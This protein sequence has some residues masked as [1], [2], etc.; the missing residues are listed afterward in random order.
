MNR[1]VRHLIA[2]AAAMLGLMIWQILFASV[3]ALKRLS[4]FDADVVYS[5]VSQIV[6][7]GALPL[8]VLLALGGSEPKNTFR[9]MRYKPP[10]DARSCLLICLGLILLI[11]PFTMA[12]NALTNLLFAVFGYKRSHPVGTI[13]LGVGDFFAMLAVTAL[14][15]A[16]FEEF[17]HRGVLLSGLEYRGSERT[18]IL[19]SAVLFGLMHTSPSQMIFATFG[20]IVFAYVAIKCDSILPAMCAHFANNAI[21]VLLDYSSQTQNALGVW[22]DKVSGTALWQVALTFAVLALS[23]FGMVRLMQ[24]AARKAPKPVSEGRL[25]G[26]TTVDVYNPEGK[27]TLSD[28][29]LLWGVTIS[30]S[31]LLVGLFLW[32]ILK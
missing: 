15:P 29:A 31:V 20:G 26:V 4:D 1:R 25:L 28:N 17:S 2:Y 30:E 23:L 11:T 5:L 9:L 7:M 21:A 10:R 27:P 6:C 16:V 32:G 18:A 19:W 22:Y 14:L 13:Y 12:F 24:F 3:P 8:C